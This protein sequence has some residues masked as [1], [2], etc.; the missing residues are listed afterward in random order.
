MLFAPASLIS[1]GKKRRKCRAGQKGR[2]LSH[3]LACLLPLAN[4]KMACFYMQQQ[5]TCGYLANGLTV[6]KIIPLF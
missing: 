2:G 1:D 6:K 5:A 4:F 3:A